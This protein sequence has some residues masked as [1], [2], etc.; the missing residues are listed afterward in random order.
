MHTIICSNRF[1]TF[2]AGPKFSTPNSTEAFRFSFKMHCAKLFAL[3][4]VLAISALAAVNHPPSLPA[5][6]IHTSCGIGAPCYNDCC[7]GCSSS[8]FFCPPNANPFELN[9]EWGHCQPPPPCVTDVCF[10]T[11]FNSQSVPSG[12]VVWL[13][14]VFKPK[15]TGTLSGVSFTDSSVTI[16]NIQVSPA[17]PNSYI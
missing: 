4:A 3:V 1:K 9:C 2:E 13:S 11:H 12:S 17:P 6:T 5:R 16:N 15:F 7:S 8:S 10:S 14:A